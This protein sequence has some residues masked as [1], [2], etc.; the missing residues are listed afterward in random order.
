MDRFVIGGMKHCGKSTHGRLL[1]AGR[2]LPF[3]DTDEELEQF[4][5]K[6]TGDALST[7]EIY[8][9]LGEEEF[10]KLE[11]EVVTK[12]VTRPGGRVVALGGGAPGNRFVD[13]A[14]WEDCGCFIYLEIDPGEAFQRV[15]AG[16][17]P[18]FLAGADD[19]RR[20]FMRIYREREQFYR[21]YADVIFRAQENASAEDN[22]AALA[23][24]VEKYEQQLR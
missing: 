18:P 19:P 6:R 7:R 24:E 3:F 1:A 4:Y 15:K 8:R 16:G 17:L 13:P 9:K 11:A 20:E 5:A 12:L 2:K 14:V 21:R 22:A 10:R 23:K